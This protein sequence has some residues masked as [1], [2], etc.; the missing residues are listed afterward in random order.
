MTNNAL[1]V[2]VSV[3]DPFRALCKVR[4]EFIFVFSGFN[5]QKLFSCECLDIQRGVWREISSIGRPRTKFSAVPISKS[6]ILLFGGKQ[7]DGQRTGEIEEYNLKTNKFKL[8]PFKMPKPRS[9]F[10][11]CVKKEEG[12]IFF[13]GGNSSSVLRKFDCLDLKKGK[14]A[15][16]EEMI[17]KRDE[18]AVALGPDGKIYAIGGY[19]GGGSLPPNSSQGGDGSTDSKSQSNCLRTAERYDFATGQWEMLPEMNQ[20]RRA[21]AA[22]ALPDGIYAIGGFDGKHYL[23]SVEKFDLHLQKWVQVK[24]MQKSRCTLAAVASP[25]CQYIYALG[26][27]NGNSLDLVERYDTVSDSW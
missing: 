7:M 25:D 24:S 13:C 5:D 2:D 27:F 12:K 21:L 16:L 6:R 11:A 23:D 1:S 20:A 19:G 18:L 3:S 15:K 14:W 4:E 17:Q 10:A 8:L 9:G 22:V 26:G